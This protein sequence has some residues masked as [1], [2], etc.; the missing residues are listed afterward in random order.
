[1]SKKT[2]VSVKDF[3][4]ISL[5]QIAKRSSKA[6]RTFGESIKNI[7]ANKSTIMTATT[8]TTFWLPIPFTNFMSDK[9]DTM[10]IPN[11]AP[12]KVNSTLKILDTIFRFLLIKI[13]P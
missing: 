3:V 10:K 5:S 4:W 8:V 6:L 1:M 12:I 2:I 11:S 7:S 13:P 9:R